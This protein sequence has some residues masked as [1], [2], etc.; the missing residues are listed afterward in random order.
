MAGTQLAYFW[1]CLLPSGS[2]TSSKGLLGQP[3]L[4]LFWESS[5]MPYVSS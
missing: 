4:L 1:C 5:H 3:S 2:S